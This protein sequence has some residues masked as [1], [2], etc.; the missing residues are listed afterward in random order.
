MTTTNA[1]ILG[2][3][4]SFAIV[5][6][7]LNLERFKPKKKSQHQKPIDEI[8]SGI[9]NASAEQSPIENIPSE[10]TKNKDYYKDYEFVNKNCTKLEDFI[11]NDEINSYDLRKLAD[12][13]GI[14]LEI[15]EGWYPL[16]IDLIKELN[17][18]G[19]DKKVSCIKEKYAEL[20]FY[21]NHKYGDEI[22]NIIEKY[23]EKSEYICETC[24][25]R[26][27]IRYNS[28]WQYVACKKH[29]LEKRGKITLEE[30][31]FQHNG[32]S[33]LWKDVKNA[34]LK[35]PDYYQNYKFLILEF[36]ENIIN[37]AGWDSSKLYISKNVMGFGN[38]L[39]NLPETFR[40]LNRSYLQYYKNP[41]FCAYCGYKAVYNNTCECCE[42]D[43]WE[44]HLTK[45]K[46]ENTEE[47]KLDFIKHRQIS[48]T[49]DEGE[50]YE[51]TQNNY[52]K[53]PNHQILF[54]QEE[55]KKYEELREY[56]E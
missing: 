50:I 28:S 34:V 53:N 2:L 9:N 14:R 27:K 36:K 45:L 16:V 51:K 4:I 6:I 11:I 46:E 33:Y 47:R 55:L 3:L 30:N 19:W 35:D 37:H 13:N 24:G 56:E 7:I 54:T 39:G 23:G 18:H 15:S 52:P 44:Y 26:G 32:T 20:K 22:S 12:L 42:N 5:Y 48:W 31:G 40:N 49:I 8:H 43:T 17:A 1:I 25:E 29:Y 21:T 38:F 41:E 10:Q